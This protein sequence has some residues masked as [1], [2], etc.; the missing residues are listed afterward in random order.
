MFV[1]AFSLWEIW[2]KQSLRKLRLPAD[3][4]ERLADEGFE[5]LL[6]TADKTLTGYGEAVLLAR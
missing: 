4:E 6:L 1:S 2:L 5:S 3:F